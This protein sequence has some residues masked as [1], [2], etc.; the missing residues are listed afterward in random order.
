MFQG[1]HRFVTNM[2]RSLHKKLRTKAQIILEPS[3]WHIAH[4]YRG[5]RIDLIFPFDK[6]LN[7]LC[8][9]Q[10]CFG[11]ELL[12]FLSHQA[13][14]MSQHSGKIMVLVQNK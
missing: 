9:D 14:C 1:G 3:K 13:F 6:I 12:P 5:E 2:A 11:A 7:C 8:V 10:R 4:E